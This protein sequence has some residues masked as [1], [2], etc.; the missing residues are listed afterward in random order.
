QP[1][2]LMAVR[3]LIL[4]ILGF[5]LGFNDVALAADPTGTVVAPSNEFG[6]AGAALG[7]VWDMNS[8]G[9][10][11]WTQPD[12]NNRTVQY[13]LHPANAPGVPPGGNGWVL[14]GVTPRGSDLATAFYT[15]STVSIPSHIYRYLIYRSYL[16]PHQPNELG[17][18]LTNARILYSSQ[19]DSNWQAVAFPNRR[20][21]KPQRL[22]C[23]P[24][25]TAYGGWC[26]FFVDLSQNLYVA[27]GP[28]PWDW[29]QPGA[30]VE[31]I[32]LWP[33]EN[34]CNST[35]AP[36]GDSPDYFYLDFV[37]LTGEIV[38]KA[39]AY[40][41]TVR[42]NIADA[43]GGQL[44]SSLYYQQQDEIRLP[45]QSPSCTAANLATAWTPIPGGTTSVT[46]GAAPAQPYRFFLPLLFKGNFNAFGSGV[47]DPS[48]Q[49]FTWNLSTGAY[50]EGK[51][52][53]VCVVVQDSQ[54]NK[55]YLASSA[56]VIKVPPATVFNPNNLT[57]LK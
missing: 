2:L 18:Q 8:L 15:N 33:H 50:I 53:Y 11:A 38:A 56:P 25:K 52:Y 12:A 23:P 57:S 7:N 42:W 34:W 14:R 10:V 9:D 28:N 29:G 46:V 32:G 35:C 22:E 6:D 43:D 48:N 3:T 16:A 24:P 54:G 45:A 4:A 47:V 51:V 13:T 21:S 49:S 5:G 30:T 19:W 44:V 40:N 26:N 37:Y 1:G 20:Y 17:I 39:P 41:Y 31:A 55:N 27:G 36:S